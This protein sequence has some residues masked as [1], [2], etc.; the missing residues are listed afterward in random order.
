MKLG[1]II[2]NRNEAEA[3]PHVVPRID[4]SIMEFV[5]A[6][7]G[8]STDG[9]PEMLENLGVEVLTQKSP[10]RGEAF[11]LA[12][13]EAERRDID[14]LIFF[15]PDGNENPDD[16]QRFRPLLEDGADMV[17]ASRMMTGAVNEEDVHLFR[18]RKWANLV[19]NW[20]AYLTWGR[21]RNRVT[22]GINGYRA[23]TTRA[24]NMMA[25][26][27]PGYTIEYQT[28]IKAYKLGLSVKE[29]PTEEG[30]RIGGESNAKAVSTGL[31]FLKLYFSEIGR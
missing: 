31:A 10:G 25:P 19:F 17:I 15:S 12:F 27:G 1:V 2:L 29:F 6:V 7:D 28:T 30:Q 14:A 4:R 23:I 3:I 11:R 9:S 8:N 18:P 5:A 16:L 26:D 24:W 13:E 22:D 21:R 20:M